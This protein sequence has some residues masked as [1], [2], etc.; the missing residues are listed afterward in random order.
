MGLRSKGLVKKGMMGLGDMGFNT[1]G[2]AIN[3]FPGHMAAA[4]STIRDRLKFADF[5]EVRDA[6]IPLSSAN[7][8]T[9]KCVVVSSNWA[10]SYNPNSEFKRNCGLLGSSSYSFLWHILITNPKG[11]DE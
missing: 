3:W 1:G 6:R 10:A 2:G 9:R 11:L 8:G 5:I 7:F 4:T